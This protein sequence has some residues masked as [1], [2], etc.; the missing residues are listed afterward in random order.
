MSLWIETMLFFS[1]MALPVY[2]V[3]TLYVKALVRLAGVGAL[4]KFILSN[5]LFLITACFSVAPIGIAFHYNE[6]WRVAFGKDYLYA[7][8]FVVCYLLAVCP[9]WLYLTRRYK[10][11]LRAAGFSYTP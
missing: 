5:A 2:L 11:A 6:A 8:F 10:E 1:M 7:G 9:S 3:L 4:I